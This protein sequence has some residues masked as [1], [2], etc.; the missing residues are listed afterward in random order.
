VSYTRGIDYFA[1]KLRRPR[2]E[3][4]AFRIDLN[5]PGLDIVVSESAPGFQAGHIPG[6][7]VT[8]F[9][10]RYNCI[11]G[12][13][14]NP[15]SPVSGKEGEDRKITGI[16]LS[17]GVLTA[18][19]D[20]GY[21]ALVFYRGG[22]GR[23]LSQSL[24]EHPEQ[25]RHISNAVG[26]FFIVLWEGTLPERLENSRE[27]PPRHPRSAAGLSADGRTLY[28]LVI[29]GRRPG[30]AGATEAETGLSSD[31]WGHLRALTLTAADPRPWRCVTP[32]ER[33]ER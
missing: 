33:F 7:R 19:P 17:D 9:V 3:F 18:P 10:K 2:L 23:I 13:N 16:T 31:A 28:L 29:D 21:D 11:L 14:A 15:F 24:L 6:T 1:G 27:Q 32:M 26:G 12:I 5:D 22:T 20:P 8:G 30:S 4:W 25:L